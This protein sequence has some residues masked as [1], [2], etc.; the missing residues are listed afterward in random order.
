MTTATK[1]RANKNLARRLLPPTAD[2]AKIAGKDFLIM[3]LRDFEEWQEDQLLAAV[4]AERLESG[5][6]IVPFEEIEDRLDRKAK[7]RK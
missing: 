7:S 5:E 1:P 2:V 6:K 3:P 4:V